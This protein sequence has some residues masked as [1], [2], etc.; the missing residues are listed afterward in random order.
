ML[1]KTFNKTNSFSGVV[2]STVD[3]SSYVKSA[4]GATE[5]CVY[6]D[7]LAQLCLKLSFSRV[8]WPVLTHRAL[9]RIT[10]VGE[11]TLDISVIEQ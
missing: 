9:F 10:V 7:L 11:W 1:A 8:L 4:V 5:R 2:R 6:S 3:A